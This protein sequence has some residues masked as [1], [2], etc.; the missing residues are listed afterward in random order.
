[1]ETEQ[2]GD[3]APTL[4]EKHAA[5]EFALQSDAL[6]RSE[7]LK[8]FLSY[9]CTVEF[10][11]NLDR[12]TEYDIAVSALGR[13]AEFSPVEDSTVRGR[14]HELRQKLE[15]LY[16]VEAP[17][18]PVRI[19]LHKG[20]YRPRF[21]RVP[22]RP[23]GQP[24]SSPAT[25]LAQGPRSVRRLVGISLVAVALLV[26]SLGTIYHL[27]LQHEQVV[28]QFWAP[29]MS[30]QQPVLIFIGANHTYRLSS[31]FLD[32]YRTLHRLENTGQEFFIDLKKGDQIDE[33]DLV[34][35]REL[36]GFGDVAATARMASM[37]TR[38]NK[39]YD[40]RYG[41]DIAVTDLH[42][43]PTIL[44]GGFSNAWSHELMHHLPFQ[45]ESGDRIVD[46]SNKARV[47][48]RQSSP[49]TFAGDDYAVISRLT[50]SETGNFVLIIA[51]IDTFSN[52]AAADLLD[53]PQRMRALLL[54]LPT[55]WEKKNLQFVLHT[56]VIKDVPSV[57]NVEAVNVW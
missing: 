44:I 14:A 54:T 28:D 26:T 16:T 45:L 31:E 52:Q 11:G 50:S 13:R 36:I 47:W 7:R 49:E 46:T 33:S 1:M 25:I 48:I 5:L 43:S 32:R 41:N 29:I 2:N 35:N 51:G 12:L 20:S 53:D 27:H 9:I 21:R 40:L 10:N 6:G 23:A 56:R 38:F 18:Y 34:P 15:R 42:S 55:G 3:A 24:E 17:H 22:Q 57:V 39:R 37:L 30:A 4:E 19:D 8:C